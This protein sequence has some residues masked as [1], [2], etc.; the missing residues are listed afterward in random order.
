MWTCPVCERTF[1]HPN[2]SHSCAV[3]DA[4]WHLHA[5]SEKIKELYHALTEK[6][7]ELKH[8]RYSHIKNAI[9]VAAGS[10]FLAIKLKK[11]FIDVEFLFDREIHEFPVYKTLRVS[12]NRV[13]HYIKLHT[14]EDV[15]PQLIKWL[16]QS[17][18]L[19]NQE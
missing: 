3:Y 4:E 15:N 10:T 17:Y 5:K 1:K 19:V 18:N 6:I 11:D 16:H 14:K 13:A 2:Q 12:K 8:V 7:N 9:T